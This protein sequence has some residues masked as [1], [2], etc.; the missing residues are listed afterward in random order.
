MKF[1]ICLFTLM[2]SMTSF[3]RSQEM[4][5]NQTN[6]LGAT[7]GHHF[8][9]IDPGVIPTSAIYRD[10]EDT[11]R[12]AFKKSW[13]FLSSLVKDGKHL[14]VRYFD[15]ADSPEIYATT[16]ILPD[17]IL[18]FQIPSFVI[19][20]DL[21]KILTAESKDHPFTAQLQINVQRNSGRKYP[22]FQ[23]RRIGVA[24]K[25]LVVTR[26]SEEENGQALQYLQ[27]RDIIPLTYT[28]GEFYNIQNDLIFEVRGQEIYDALRSLRYNS[29]KGDTFYFSLGIITNQRHPYIYHTE[30]ISLDPS[31]IHIEKT[32]DGMGSP[33]PS[34]VAIYANERRLEQQLSINF[35]MGKVLQDFEENKTNFH[36]VY[37][38][39]N[40][41]LQI[42]DEDHSHTQQ[43]I[44]AIEQEMAEIEKNKPQDWPDRLSQLTDQLQTLTAHL[45]KSG[46]QIKEFIDLLKQY[47][48]QV[49]PPSS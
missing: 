25:V 19:P 1:F 31:Q 2:L 26:P 28:G 16:N 37:Q 14:V 42:L 24:D 32:V 44:Q 41:I 9:V 43:E 15:I 29:Q 30:E 5:I 23:T 38:Q 3:A 39:L 17:D 20:S 49:A 21:Q 4:Q 48:T 22:L 36:T 45:A 27:G 11:A 18:I 47:E 40:A 10:I 46:D 8:Y 6:S 13:K 12:R 35:F 33:D 7:P 34:L